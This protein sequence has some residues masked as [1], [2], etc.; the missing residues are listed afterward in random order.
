MTDDI[1]AAHECSKDEAE[2]WICFAEKIRRMD[3]LSIIEGNRREAWEKG[4]AEEKERVV[5]NF[6]EKLPDL[7]K[8]AE[9]LGLDL[10][11]V[12]RIAEKFGLLH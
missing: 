2:C 1:T 4:V 7:S 3:E 8:A 6:L 5:R 10:K 11:E 9:L 12:R